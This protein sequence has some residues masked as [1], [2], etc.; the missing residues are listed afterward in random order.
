MTLEA[1]KLTTFVDSF[2]SLAIHI[3]LCFLLSLFQVLD[4]LQETLHVRKICQCWS[5]YLIQP[6]NK[7]VKLFIQIP[8]RAR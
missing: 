6:S 4:A 7:M 2:I 8:E 1:L 3:Y 5:L